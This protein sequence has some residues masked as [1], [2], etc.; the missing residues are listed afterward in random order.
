MTKCRALIV[1]DERLARRELSFLL[2]NHPEI[3]MVGEAGSVTEAVQAVERLHPELIF[4]DIQMPPES[5][6]DLFERT[7]V[8]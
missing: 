7:R 4:L 5:G 6:F 3:E 2:Q 1:D 8:T